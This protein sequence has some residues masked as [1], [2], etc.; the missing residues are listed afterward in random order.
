M[1]GIR[2]RHHTARSG[3]FPVPLPH[4]PFPFDVQ[5][6]VCGACQEAT[7]RNIRHACK[8]VHLKLDAEGCAI[9]ARPIWDDFCRVV[10]RA[11]F[12]PANLVLEPPSQSFTPPTEK[13]ELDG[14]QFG[15]TQSKRQVSVSSGKMVR[16]EVVPDVMDLESYVD[17]CARMGIG[18]ERALNALLVAAL[19]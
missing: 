13:V 16:P 2:I 4:K 15:V 5:Q 7:G 18:R 3:L 6:P 12:V 11:G 14:I 17:K 8:T 10:N 1:Y 19:K 9:V